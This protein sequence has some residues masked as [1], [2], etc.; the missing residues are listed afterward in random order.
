[1]TRITLALALAALVAVPAC[2]GKK[3]DGGAAKTTEGGKAVEG[4]KA[5]EGAKEAPKAAAPTMDAPALWTDYNKPGQDGMALMKKWE[6]GVI[7]TGTVKNTIT[8]EAGNTSVWLDGGDNHNV[9]LGFKDDGKAA[10]EKG[11]KKDD[12]VTAQC[13]IGGS[14]G[15]N[16]M[17]LTDCELK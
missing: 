17:M 13:Q 8:E 15:N 5:A 2:G 3:E 7:V 9:T 12:K 1:M 4:G 6:N 10:K 14:D 16:M 11:I